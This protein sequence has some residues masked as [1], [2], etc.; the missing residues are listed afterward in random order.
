MGKTATNLSVVLGLAIIAFAGYY[1]YTQ[2]DATT[3]S[4]DSNQQIMQNKIAGNL[5]Y[6]AYRKDLESIDMKLGFFEDPRF[7]SLRN[8]RTPIQESL[9]GRDN[10]FLDREERE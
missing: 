8:F 5:N 3:L 4:L 1:L 7:T 10:P 9:V 2:R 6:I